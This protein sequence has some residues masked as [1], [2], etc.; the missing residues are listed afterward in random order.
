M[1]PSATKV[2]KIL[3]IN[4]AFIGDV[5]LSTPVSKGLRETYPEAIIDMLVIPLTEPIAAGNLCINRV[6]IYDKHGRHKRLGELWKLIQ[7]LRQEKYDL[8]LSMNFA[9]RGAMLA[10]AIGAKRRVG[11]NRQH[12]GLFLTDY[13]D[14]SRDG[15]CHETANHLKI[16]KPL[17]ITVNDT[18]LL[19]Q[20]KEPDRVSMRQKVSFSDRPAIAICPFGS[21]PKKSWSIAKYAKLLTTLA[22]TTDCYLIGATSDRAG[23]EKI[24]DE[25]KQNIKILAGDLPLAELAAFLEQVKLLITVDTGPMHIA[26]ALNTPIVALFGPTDPR[27]WGPRGE[28]TQI[29]QTPV[30]CAP[31]WGKAE[32]LEHHCMEGIRVSDVL[33][34][35][36]RQLMIN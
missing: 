15:L 28:Q 16:L 14:S 9:P 13:A 26:E 19:F 22:I 7:T 24:R 12:G 20:V 34:A 25:A 35:V 1:T 11:Y 36:N 23:L 17:G 33:K 18:H 31:C 32:C 21:Y 8:S 4:L 5:L 6:F 29:L 2:N 30:P 10:W 3:L 27:I